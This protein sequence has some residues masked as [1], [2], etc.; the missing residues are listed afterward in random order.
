VRDDRLSGSESTEKWL[1]SGC[2]LREEPTEFPE[3]LVV[4]VSEGKG[5]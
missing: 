4:G 3:E 2:I 1:D 5:L